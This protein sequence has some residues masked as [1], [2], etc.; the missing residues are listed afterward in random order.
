LRDG[1]TYI[2]INNS[3]FKFLYILL[4]GCFNQSVVQPG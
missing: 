1:C 2:C 4:I 3:H